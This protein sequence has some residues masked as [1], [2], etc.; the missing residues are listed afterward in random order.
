MRGTSNRN[1]PSLRWLGGYAKD[2][3]ALLFFLADFFP[4]NCLGQHQ[5]D[6]GHRSALGRHGCGSVLDKGSGAVPR[7][8]NPSQVMLS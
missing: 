7:T 3:P 1:A 4:D 2:L 5:G 6:E 8:H